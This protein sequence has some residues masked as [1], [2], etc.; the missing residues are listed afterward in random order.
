M[1]AR[2]IIAACFDIPVGLL[3]MEERS[4]AN[5]EVVAPH[6]QLM[7]IR[8]R[9]QRLEDKIN[10]DLTPDFREALN[11]P[12]LLVVFE[13]PVDEDR[14]KIVLQVSTLAGGKPLITQD[15]ARAQLGMPPLTPEQKEE[16]APPEPTDPFSGGG[17]KDS[18]SKA[19][20]HGDGHA[21]VWDI[22]TKDD[23][24]PSITRSM[25][26][27]AEALTRIFRS[28][29]STYANAPIGPGLA[30]DIAITRRLTLGVFDAIEE[31]LNAILLGGYN[32]G[33]DDVNSKADLDMARREAFAANA[34]EAIDDYRLVLSNAVTQTYEGRVRSVIQAGL[35]Q[36]ANPNEIA[37]AVRTTIPNEAP[38]SADRIARTETSRALNKG[39]D[40]AYADS[41]IV[42]IREWLL[43]GDPCK[44]CREVH[45]KYRFAKVGEPFVKKGTV[46]AGKVMDYADIMG[47]DAHPQCSCGVSAVIKV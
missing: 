40:M 30:M 20:W 15:E 38:A 32:R 47:G 6:W 27:M 37:Q 46:V 14:E 4:L 31:P 34:V 8:P 35:K 44:V 41:G 25:R 2:N 28:F 13:N 24:V 1:D 10:E 21:H 12:T 26:V 42:T 11:D 39:K 16:L 9:V 43:S 18:Q 3:N 22:E 23:K 36:G 19:L 29:A 45:A 7:S 17:G 33:V 5:G